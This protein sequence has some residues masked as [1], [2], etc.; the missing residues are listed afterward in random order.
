MKIFAE[1]ERLILR[2]I[3][4]TDDRHL[5]ELDSDPEVHTYVGRKPVTTIAECR[6]VIEN[7]RGQYQKHGIGRWA[8]VLKSTHEFIGWAGLKLV[9]EPVNN[10]TGYYDLGYRFMR[11]H[12]GKGY[13]S[14]VA[15]ASVKYGFGVLGLKKI[16]AYAHSENLASRKVLEKTDLQFIELFQEAGEENAWY[17]I[18]NPAN[19]TGSL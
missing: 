15:G 6:A 9:T 19:Q 5:F 16:N 3:L 7:I 11:K 4:P 2:E 14:E 1:T 18:K 12:W 8:V 13:A 17:E 10:H